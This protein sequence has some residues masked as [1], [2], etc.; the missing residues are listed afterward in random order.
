MAA[1]GKLLQFIL[2]ELPDAVNAKDRD[3]DTA[4]HLMAKA[5]RD[6]F[7]EE[8]L[9]TVMSILIRYY[10]HLQLLFTIDFVALSLT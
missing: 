8:D 3:G 7:I 4:L 5:P 2:H 9:T 6:V 10:F 1:S